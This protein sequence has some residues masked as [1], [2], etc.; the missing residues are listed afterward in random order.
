MAT[1]A[2]VSTVH[3]RQLEPK[4]WRSNELKLKHAKKATSSTAET[5]AHALTHVCALT[6]APQPRLHIPH[7]RAR[8]GTRVAGGTGEALSKTT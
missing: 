4:Y 3:T 8:S 7:G 5:S 2:T 1:R 6:F